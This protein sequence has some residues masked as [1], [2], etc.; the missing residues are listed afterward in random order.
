[1]SANAAIPNLKNRAY[2]AHIRGQRQLKADHQAWNPCRYGVCLHVP[3][4]NYTQESLMPRRT[5][6]RP[7]AEYGGAHQPVSTQYRYLGTDPSPRTTFC[8]APPQ[9]SITVADPRV[10]ASQVTSTRSRPSV[11]AIIRD[12]PMMAVA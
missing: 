3:V 1:M 8:S 4:D 11:E 10:F 12:W 9:F 7:L 2:A 5:A 6:P